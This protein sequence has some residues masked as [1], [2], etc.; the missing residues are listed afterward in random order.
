MESRPGP[1]CRILKFSSANAAPP[2]MLHTPEPSPWNG[3][4]ATVML[5]CMDDHF[6]VWRFRIPHF[7]L[8]PAFGRKFFYIFELG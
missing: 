7:A 1:S 6:V 8:E 3:G 2:Y 4:T 5:G